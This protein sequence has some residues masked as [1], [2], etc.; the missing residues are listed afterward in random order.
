MKSKNIKAHIYAEIEKG[1]FFSQLAS[2]VDI[3]RID[4]QIIEG[5]RFQFITKPLCNRTNPDN[6]ND[7]NLQLQT[8]HTLYESGEEL[9]EGMLKYTQFKHHRH[10]RYL[11]DNNAG[12]LA[13]MRFV[14]QPFSFV[15]LLEGTEQFH[16]ILETL[17]TEEASFL[18]HFPERSSELPTRLK[19]IDSHLDTIRKRGRQGFLT[20]PP[21]NFS[22]LFHDYSDVQ[23]GFIVWKDML[24]ERIV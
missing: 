3:K 18:W 22:C 24:E 6:I 11:A 21:E 12:H 8:E 7:V 1:Q 23:G 13:K 2:S 15:F 19:E 20:A 10:L 14:L 17:D 4:T 9:L 16:I 5:V